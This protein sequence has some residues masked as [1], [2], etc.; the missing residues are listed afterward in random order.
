ML[1]NPKQ[2]L[3][4][5]LWPLAAAAERIGRA[6][7][8]LW[9]YSRLHAALPG[10]DASVVILGVPEIHGT[11]AIELGRD[12]YLYRELYLETREAGQI[13]IGDRVVIS[14]GVHLVAF[15][16]IDIGPGAMIGEYCSIRDANHRFGDGV[17]LRESGHVARAIRIGANAWIGRGVTLLPGV[18]VGAGAVIG[19]NAVVTADV[20]AGAVYAGVPAR[21]LRKEAA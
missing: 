3:A 20:P 15:A 18:Q 1:S 4:M 12:L 17:A 21:P 14:R 11:R 6:W 5:G 16:G 13:R 2:L 10:V 9:A 7:Q 8:R 19:A